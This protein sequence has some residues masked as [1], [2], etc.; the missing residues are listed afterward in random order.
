MERDE[1]PSQHEGQNPGPCRNV[2]PSIFQVDSR[3]L[4]ANQKELV[5]EHRRM[6]LNP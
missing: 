3:M 5:V 2:C 4:L 1:Y 6:H